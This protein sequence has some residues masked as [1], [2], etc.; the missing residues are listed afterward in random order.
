[1]L[2]ADGDIVITERIS[3]YPVLDLLRFSYAQVQYVIVSVEILLITY[4]SIFLE[5]LCQAL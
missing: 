3:F 5:E 4:Q 1:M 2:T